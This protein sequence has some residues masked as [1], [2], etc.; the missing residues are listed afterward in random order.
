MYN[1]EAVG[2]R[3]KSKTERVV[4]VM[5]AAVGIGDGVT[6]VNLK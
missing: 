3:P 5:L 6:I 1:I 2:I 4:E